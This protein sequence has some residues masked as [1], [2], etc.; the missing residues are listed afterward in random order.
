MCATAGDDK[1]EAGRISKAILA[2]L[3][4]L[5]KLAKAKAADDVPK[6][7][8]ALKGHVLEFIKVS[9]RANPNP[10]P[11]PNP[12]LTLTLT[13]ALTQTQ[14]LTLTLTLTNPNPNQNPNPNPNQLEPKRLAERFGE[15]SDGVVED[16]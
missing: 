9:V 14:T 13:L 8:A 7:S 15:S 3:K 4:G 16:L 12:D 5:D 2:D 10:N 6:A 11:D 1:A